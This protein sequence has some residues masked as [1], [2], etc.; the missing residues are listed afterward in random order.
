M[1]T[2][3]E[4][5][6]IESYDENTN[7]IHHIIK[8]YAG[9]IVYESSYK[10]MSPENKPCTPIDYLRAALNGEQIIIIPSYHEDLMNITHELH[11]LNVC[12]T[13]EEKEKPSFIR[14]LRCQFK[15]FISIFK[16]I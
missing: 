16:S 15:A 12:K 5:H 9:E 8:D 10:V 6:I 2:I 3:T 7:T 4:F 13:N 14:R 1:K 11:M